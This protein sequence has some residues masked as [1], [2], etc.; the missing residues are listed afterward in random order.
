MRAPKENQMDWQ[1]HCMTSNNL[2]R[3]EKDPN[4]NFIESLLVHKNITIF[5]NRNDYNNF[6]I[7]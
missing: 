2:H 4:K 6:I 5:D 3:L 1:Y 7:F